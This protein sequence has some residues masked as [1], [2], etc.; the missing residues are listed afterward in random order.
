MVAT[1]QGQQTLT[2]QVLLSAAMAVGFAICAGPDA[3]GQTLPA[4][5]RLIDTS[6]PVMTGTMISVPAGGDFQGALDRAQLG[7]TILLQ[8]GAT[9]SG[10]FTLAAKTGSG[11]I[12][13]RTSAA[14][15]SLPAQGRRITPSYS[16]VLP[17]IVTTNTLPAIQTVAGANHYRF[18]GVEITV[19]S[20][21]SMNYGLVYFGDS[22]QT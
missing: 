20:G 3:N 21:V 12:I 7:D 4:S 13:V 1:T 9:Y 5:P 8:A 18:V 15:S 14:D 19:A 6:Y 10:N 17:K 22:V 16:S 2:K 11:W